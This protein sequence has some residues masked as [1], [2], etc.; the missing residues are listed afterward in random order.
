MLDLWLIKQ[1]G[2]EEKGAHRLPITRIWEPEFWWSV[3]PHRRIVAWECF[4]EWWLFIQP[5]L[6]ASGQGKFAPMGKYKGVGI[7]KASEAM[8]TQRFPWL[9]IHP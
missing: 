9:S 7:T 6:A 2:K 4:L 5:Q 1:N 8:S 3:L